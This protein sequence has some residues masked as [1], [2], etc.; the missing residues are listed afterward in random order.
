VNDV[1]LTAV[2]GALGRYIDFR[3]EARDVIIRGFIPVNLRPIELDEEL[4][5]KFGLVFLSLPMGIDDPIKRLGRV[6]QNMDALKTSSE[7]VA[8]FGV[9]NLFGA[10]PLCLED[11]LVDFFD[12]KG[13]TVITNVPGP[14]EQLYLAGAPINTV[15]AWVPQTGRIA[16][17]I[18]IIS[19][20]GKVWLGVATDKGLVPDPETIVAFFYDEY[21][22][23]LSRAQQAQ[24]ARQKHIQPIL[25]ML[26]QATQTL[27]EL[28][29]QSSEDT[30][31]QKQ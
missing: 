22:E 11:V 14:Q 1:L 12:T 16:L 7:P 28:L 21:K 25:S 6:K 9:I 8:T 26:D 29:T 24:A 31:S 10:V 19:Y 15:M 2:A 5:N 13:T 30:D 20:N 18:S 17:G 27:A 23:L 3:G 4:G